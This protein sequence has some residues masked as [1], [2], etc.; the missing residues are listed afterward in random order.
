[1]SISSKET[2]IIFR[3]E[4]SQLDRLDRMIRLMGYRTRNEWFRHN[5]REFISKAEKEAY[6]KELSRLDT[7]DISDEDIAEMV[8]T[9]RRKK[10][11]G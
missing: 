7:N 5:I 9:W 6:E 10:R 11:A 1:M 3:L 2:Q 4:K 8:K